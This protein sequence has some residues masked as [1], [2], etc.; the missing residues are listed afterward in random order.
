MGFFLIV[1]TKINLSLEQK[2]FVLVSFCKYWVKMEFTSVYWGGKINNK[3]ARL[4]FFPVGKVL[5]LKVKGKF[6]DVSEA[7]VREQQII[8]YG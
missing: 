5:T 4:F 7:G 2:Y 1:E 8:N 3:F 6:W